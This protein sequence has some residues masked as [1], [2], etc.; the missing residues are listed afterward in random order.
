MVINSKMKIECKITSASSIVI[1]E[2]IRCLN[3]LKEI[4]FG[5]KN[6]NKI[7]NEYFQ[8]SGCKSILRNAKYLSN[9]EKLNLESNE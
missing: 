4:N 6:V 9:L 5:G 1:K 7:G 8:D 3:K 2:N